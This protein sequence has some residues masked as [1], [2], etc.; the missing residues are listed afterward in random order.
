MY[1]SIQ[2]FNEFGLRKIEK[3]IE[4]FVTEKKD[5][6][7]LVLDLQETLFELGRNIVADKM[8]QLRIYKQNGGK[9][10]DLVM[11]QKKRE[12]KENEIRERE[13]LLSSFR[14]ASTKYEDIANTNLT[15]LQMGH[16]TALY[17]ALRGIVG[18]CG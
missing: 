11:G 8:A 17:K 10:Y 16:K 14:T 6:A 18:R 4:T 3:V 7:D 12:Q 15:V 1:N 9:I 2:H 5:L 13:E